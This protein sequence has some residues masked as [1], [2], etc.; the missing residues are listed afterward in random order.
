M[1]TPTNMNTGVNVTNPVGQTANATNKG[2]Q[3]GTFYPVHLV[4]GTD[5]GDAVTAVLVAQWTAP[6][7][8]FFRHVGYSNYSSAATSTFLVY[9]AT[10]AANVIGAVTPTSNVAGAVTSFTTAAFAE[11][12]VIQLRVTTS[13]GSGASKGLNVWLTAVVTADS[14]SNPAY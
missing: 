11:G 13:G 14:G 1:A 9:N 7:A 10:Q 6:F 12:D 2:L 5:L 8:G 4:Q 3:I